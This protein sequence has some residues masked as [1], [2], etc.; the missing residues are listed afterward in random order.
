MPPPRVDLTSG[1][2][3]QE[4]GNT[5]SWRLFEPLAEMLLFAAS[6]LACLGHSDRGLDVIQIGRFV[7]SALSFS[8]Y[9]RH[10]PTRSRLS[11]GEPI[12][13][14]FTFATRTTFSLSRAR[15]NLSRLKPSEEEL[16]LNWPGKFNGTESCRRSLSVYRRPIDGIESALPAILTRRLEIGAATNKISRQP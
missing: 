12:G 16:P 2:S 10:Q 1:N 13:R 11:E 15:T 4:A 14:T 7:A 6:L 5:V 9:I 3:E 8:F